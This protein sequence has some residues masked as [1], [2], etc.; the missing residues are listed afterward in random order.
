MVQSGLIYRY[1]TKLVR[2]TSNRIE[3]SVSRCT[4]SVKKLMFS[5]SLSASCR[6]TILYIG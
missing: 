4:V 6:L 2:E 3:P 1:V 5:K